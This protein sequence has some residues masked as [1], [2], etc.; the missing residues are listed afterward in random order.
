MGMLLASVIR[1]PAAAV[2]FSDFYYI[3][4]I[5]TCKVAPLRKNFT[6]LFRML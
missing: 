1:N 3:K 2:W 6:L 5:R 4:F